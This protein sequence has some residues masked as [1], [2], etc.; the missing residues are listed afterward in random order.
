D[1]LAD[2]GESWSERRGDWRVVIADDGD[3]LWNLPASRLEKAHR[4]R[5]H[6]VRCGEHGVD[7]RPD[8]QESLHRRR[9]AVLGEV[10]GRDER[11]VMRDPGLIQRL[12]VAREPVDA[13]AHVDRAGDR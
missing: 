7:V 6:E 11:R 8:L 12:A 1:R 13:G 10:A 9:A 5:R 2:A 4:T 3:V